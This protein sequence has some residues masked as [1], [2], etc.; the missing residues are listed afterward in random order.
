MN[1]LRFL[2]SLGICLCLLSGCKE[3]IDVSNIDARAEI[4]MGLVLPIGTAHATFADLLSTKTL[5][6]DVFLD[7][8]GVINYQQTHQ[9]KVNFHPI[10]LD[11][12]VTSGDKSAPVPVIIPGQ[13][14]LTIPLTVQMENVNTYLSNERFDSVIITQATL[15]SRLTKTNLDELSWD[16]IDKVT[17]H[18]GEQISRP[19]GKDMVIYTRGDAGGFDHSITSIFNDCSMCLMKNRNLGPDATL[20]DYNNNVTNIWEPSVTI[21][22]TVPSG[23]SFMPADDASLTYHYTFA[24]QD[25]SAIWG[26]FKPSKELVVNDSIDLS[27]EWDLWKNFKSAYFTFDRPLVHVDV[28]TSVSATVQL[29]I[30]ELYMQSKE[31][32]KIHATFNGLEQGTYE[33]SDQIGLDPSTIGNRTTYS[34]VIDS[35]KAHGKL[36]NCFAISPHLCVF[37]FNVSPR[38]AQHHPQMRL[39]KDTSSVAID[40]VSVFPFSFR[41]GVNVFYSDTIRDVNFTEVALDSLV[42]KINGVEEIKTTDLNLYIRATNGIPLDVKGKCTFRDEAGK[43]LHIADSTLFF[44]ANDV[45]TYTITVNEKDFDRIAQTKSITIDAVGSDESFRDH[46][47]RYPIKVKGTSDLKIFFGFAGN[48][49]A[50]VNFNELMKK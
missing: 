23:Q 4:D 44:K 38:D 31:G 26:F 19:Q 6:K 34:A 13:Q 10:N 18:L 28:N 25:Y 35:S 5:G 3:K 37:D 48:I 32:E 45:T 8:E 22:V 41:P 39:V 43:D 14:T 9:Y 42:K 20:D 21:D 40:V 24:I 12:Y 1:R 16:W 50:I 33:Y 49:D 11:S 15:V 29:T 36:D 7:E 30:N 27:K 47:E 2:L 46:P 17:L